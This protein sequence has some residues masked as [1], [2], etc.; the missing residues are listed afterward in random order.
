MV[1]VQLHGHLVRQYRACVI[2]SLGLGITF[3]LYHC[4]MCTRHRDLNCLLC[5]LCYPYILHPNFYVYLSH[6]TLKSADHNGAIIHQCYEQ[7]KIH[8]AGSL[9]YSCTCM[10]DKFMYTRDV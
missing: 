8:V 1:I 3:V 10:W 9:D 4:T 7:K 5:C 2:D 6:L